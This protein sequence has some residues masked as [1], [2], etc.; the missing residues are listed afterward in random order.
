MLF[1]ALKVVLA[2]GVGGEE[3]VVAGMPPGGMAEILWMVH[4]GN[5]G[6]FVVCSGAVVGDPFRALAPSFA[7]LVALGVFNRT[8]GD[9]SFEPQ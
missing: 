2:E 8:F 3:A 9:F 5:D 4:E 1:F 6:G 7:I